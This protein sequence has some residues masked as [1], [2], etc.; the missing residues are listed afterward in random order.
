MD[1]LRSRCRLCHRRGLVGSPVSGRVGLRQVDP[2]NYVSNGDAN[3]IVTITQ[4]NP[5]DVVF[6][7]PED[8]IAAVAKGMRAGPVPVTV[9]DRD[10]SDALAEGTLLTLDN[11]IDTTTGTVK[12]KARSIKR[13]NP[14]G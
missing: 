8:Q 12:A 10:Q 5:I 14:A 13:F 11:Q 9:F 3:G 1:R 7:V 6:T 2:G 4:I